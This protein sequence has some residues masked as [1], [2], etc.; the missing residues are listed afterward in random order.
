MARRSKRKSSKPKGILGRLLGAWQGL[1][2]PMTVARTSRSRSGAVKRS[3]RPAGG[4]KATVRG[5]ARRSPSQ[6]R[7]GAQ[8]SR[9]ARRVNRQMDA[10]QLRIDEIKLKLASRNLRAPERA[11]LVAEL[12]RLG[13]IDYQPGRGR[14]GR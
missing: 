13:V 14:M 5:N 6:G 10:A 4:R 2:E 3:R 9:R 12:G 1:H 8:Q 11:R 7:G